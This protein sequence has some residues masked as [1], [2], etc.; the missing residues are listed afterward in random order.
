MNGL[1]YYWHVH[2]DI[3]YET[4]EDVDDRKKNILEWK[5]KDEV[6][7]RLRLLKPIL[8][9]P[10]ELQDILARMQVAH[11]ANN[12]DYRENKLERDRCI[13]PCA[14]YLRLFTIYN[15]YWSLQDKLRD[16]MEELHRIECPGCPWNGRT[17]FPCNP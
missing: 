13:R 4:I 8:N 16:Q 14:T 17:I 11:A 7:T 2:H 6:E 9:P 5:P 15:E 1:K 10:K 12:A 3:L